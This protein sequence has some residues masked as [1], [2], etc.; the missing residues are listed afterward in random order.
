MLRNYFKT[1]IR[2]ISRNKLTASINILGLSIAIG[3]CVVVFLFV[4]LQYSADNFHVNREKIYLVNNLVDRDGTIQVWGDSPAP[5]GEL[6]KQD[7]A[8]VQ[9]IVRMVDGRAIMQYE[10]QVFSERFTYVDTNFLDVFSFELESGER[11]ALS[12][13]KNVII[14]KR[15]AEKYFGE[16]DP[17]GK[18]IT[19]K[20][21]DQ[22]MESFVIGAVA[23]K[24]PNQS[25]FR[26]NMLVN[27]DKLQ[28]ADKDFDWSDWGRFIAATFVQLDEAENISILE[29]GMSKYVQLQN[30][31]EEDWPAENY[32][33][34]PLTT[35]ALKSEDIRSSISSGGDKIARIV[36]SV[37]G[38]FMITLACFNYINIAIV[39][40]SKRLKEIGIRKAMG[41]HKRQ[42]VVQFLTENIILS[43]LAMIL[44]MI[45]GGSLFTRWFENLFS[46]GLEFR[47]DNPGVWYYAIGVVLF[48]GI[49]SGAYPA[50]YISSFDA[51][52]IFRGKQ[53]LGGRNRFTKVFLTFQFILAIIAIIGGILAV[54]NAK[55]QRQRDWGYDEKQVLSIPVESEQ[56]YRTLRNKI[57]E[58]PDIELIAGSANHIGRLTPI[59]VIEYLGEKKEVN[60]HDVG[61]NYFETLEIRLKDGRFLD[62]TSASDFE[63]VVVNETF[64][65]SLAIEDPFSTTF[66]FD[67]VQYSV[68]GIVEDFHYWS[69]FDKIQP[70]F[71]RLAKEEDYRYLTVRTIEGTSIKI[72][73]YLEQTW[74]SNFPEQPYYGMFQDQVWQWYYD[75]VDGHGKILGFVA[76]LSIILS[77]IG[78][79]GLVSLQVESR[80]KEFSIRK[81]LGAS[82]QNLIRVLNSQF[83]W[84]L[85]IAIIIGTPLGLYLIYVLF[86]SVYPYHLPIGA[87]PG[88]IA[89]LALVLT[90]FLTTST[91]IYKVLV[92]N[93]VDT[94]RNE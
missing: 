43:T 92:N 59:A 6:L 89:A 40:A 11:N 20:H 21:E 23:K 3:C 57:S 9:E 81:V 86:E 17:I 51:V 56:D 36:L 34:E 78:L 90:A 91:Q 41:S 32:T 94:L 88:I 10:D 63:H 33:F 50:F 54:Q 15:I 69:F 80:L 64:I 61:E 1:A 77:C 53:K 73:E 19:L 87:V 62:H 2:N 72:S 7:F 8:Q 31:A 42:L 75:V 66:W 28:I 74:K 4:E 24:F 29:E 85:I 58:N 37:I 93:P 46:S 14:S 26:F 5:I 65:N 13:P 30:E 25:S 84:I 38:A 83:I 49:A 67:S 27:I 35:L 18:Q 48:T 76:T 82:T 55:F 60:R 12:D 71:F 22:L 44:G 47:L 52:N 70:S 16:N 45:L 79:F 68:V 39:S